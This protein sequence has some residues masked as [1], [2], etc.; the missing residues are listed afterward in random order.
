M[1]SQER[2]F[3]GSYLVAGRNRIFLR[4]ILT[5]ICSAAN[6]PVLVPELFK[7]AGWARTSLFPLPFAEPLGP[8]EFLQLTY[9]DHTGRQS[10]VDLYW[11]TFPTARPVSATCPTIA[12]SVPDGRPVETGIT[13]AAFPGDTPFPVNRYLIARR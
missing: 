1:T 9:Q 6:R 10:D 12:L 4:A 8:G 11:P 13:A 7:T 5:T 2:S 3:R